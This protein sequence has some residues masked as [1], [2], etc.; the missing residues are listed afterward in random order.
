MHSHAFLV[1]DGVES[2]AMR[3]MEPNLSCSTGVERPLEVRKSRLGSEAA[4][5]ATL[6]S[7]K[8]VSNSILSK[9]CCVILRRR[10]ETVK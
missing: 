7:I 1:P 4:S 10:V 9:Q 2:D 3:S 5:V 6:L 8:P